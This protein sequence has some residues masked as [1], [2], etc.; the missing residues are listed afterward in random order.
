MIVPNRCRACRGGL[1]F[2]LQIPCERLTG[3][4]P[5]TME[6]NYQIRLLL[7]VIPLPLLCSYSPNPFTWYTIWFSIC[8]AWPFSSSSEYKKVERLPS[9]V[10]Q[11]YIKEIS[12]SVQ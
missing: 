6:M 9:S 4:G 3:V 11:N 5:Y 12:W 1:R 10:P 8:R 2:T 7:L